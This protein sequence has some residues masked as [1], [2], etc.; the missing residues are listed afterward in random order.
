VLLRIGCGVC[1]VQDGV[2][3]AVRLPSL[4]HLFLDN[5]AGRSHRREGSATGPA[6][7]I[8]DIDKM[9]DRRLF[10]AMPFFEE[11]TSG[12]AQVFHLIPPERRGDIPSPFV[13]RR[14]K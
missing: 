7:R 3:G 11:K 10:A 12:C 8:D 14:Y 1:D 5:Q 13:T 4:A 2:A 9:I 6:L